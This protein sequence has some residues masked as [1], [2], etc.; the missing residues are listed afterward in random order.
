MFYYVL[1]NNSNL[2]IFRKQN[3]TQLE[4]GFNSLNLKDIYRIFFIPR[5]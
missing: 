3:W 1:I 4:S 5:R 2:Q